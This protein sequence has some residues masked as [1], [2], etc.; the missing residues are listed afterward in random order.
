MQRVASH[1]VALVATGAALALSAVAIATRV[2]ARGRSR[3]SN[4]D[5]DEG[6]DDDD[7]DEDEDDE[8]D[9]E[10]EDDVPE[11]KM[12]LCVR[13]DKIGGVHKMGKGKMCA[14][15]CHAA[16]GAYKRAMKKHPKLVRRFDRH[17]SAKVAVKVES[18]E[19]L[20]ALHAEA[21]RLSAG[22]R[23]LKRSQRNRRR[24]RLDTDHTRGTGASRA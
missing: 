1:P 22:G 24:D 13:T 2:G 10:G 6:D 15:C 18:E 14:Q 5:D 8:E 12:M 7:D 23:K 3:K 4:D 16:V 19:Q 11:L 17:G 21:V 20:L 9:E